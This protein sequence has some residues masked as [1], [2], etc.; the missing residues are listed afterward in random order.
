MF[1]CGVVV[2]GCA[3]FAPALAELVLCGL[4]LAPPFRLSPKSLRTF[5]GPPNS[6]GCG[7]QSSVLIFGCSASPSFIIPHNP[8][9]DSTTQRNHEV[10]TEKQSSSGTT[11]TQNTTSTTTTNTTSTTKK[12]E[13]TNDT[14]ADYS[15][16]GGVLN[17]YNGNGGA[18]SIPSTVNGQSVTA[19]GTK[20]FEGSNITSVSIPS[21]V[22]KIGQMSFSDC[23]SLSSV[24]L[25]NT[26]TSIGDCAFD[27][28]S[29][30]KSITIP[31]SVTNIGDDAFD[32]CNNLTIRCSE[33]SAAHEYCRSVKVF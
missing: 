8:S 30:L 18:I 23:S 7:E 24:S 29:S 10:S 27:G 22:T 13:T 2:T 26:L 9:S 25:P 1:A 31:S 14:G 11:N 32:G 6:A 17:G 21:G 3:S 20:A 28:C 12:S 5:R 19:I 33:G 15:V 16:S 4:S